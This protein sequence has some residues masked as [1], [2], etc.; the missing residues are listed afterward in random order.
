MFPF[1]SMRFSNENTSVSSLAGMI[2]GLQ[3]IAVTLFFR[4]KNSLSFY[5]KKWPLF[6]PCAPSPPAL[7]DFSCLPLCVAGVQQQFSATPPGAVVATSA[8]AA[9]NTNVPSK[10]KSSIV[11]QINS[12]NFFRSAASHCQ[13]CTTPRCGCCRAYIH[14]TTTF[15]PYW[16]RH[17]A[18]L[19]HARRSLDTAHCNEGTL[20]YTDNSAFTGHRRFRSAR[21]SLS[22]QTASR[23]SLKHFNK[24]ILADHSGK[25]TIY[26][27]YTPCLKKTVQVCFYQNLGK[28]PPILIIR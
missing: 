5:L 26:L 27:T 10:V 18:A 14:G 3:S 21:S 1:S 25:K 23:R 24:H 28:F 20:K 17:R 8:I 11:Y 12:T 16:P 7:H 6:A 9:P 15:A 13:L 4:K 19:N 22:R 2:I